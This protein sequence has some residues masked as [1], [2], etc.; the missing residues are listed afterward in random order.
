MRHGLGAG[1]EEEG[2]GSALDD[3]KEEAGGCSNGT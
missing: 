1:G 2:E 3:T